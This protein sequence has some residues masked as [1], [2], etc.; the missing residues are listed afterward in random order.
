MLSKGKIRALA[1][2]SA[3]TSFSLD[4]AEVALHG[5][6]VDENDA[7]VQAA[8]VSVRPAAVPAAAA[9]SWQAQTDPDGAFIVTLPAA[10]DY[11]I[12]AE[13]EGYYALKDHA[14]HIEGA[15]ELTL[16]INSVREVFQSENVNAETSPLDVGQ[17]Q[18]QERLTGTEVNDVPY[19][20]SHSLRNSFALMPGVV[21]DATGALHANGSQENQLNYVLN[22]FNITNPISGNFQTLL[23]VEGIRDVNLAS[24][25]YSP[26][27]GKGSAGVLAIQTENGTDAFHYTA[28]DFIPGISIQNGL[29]L[30]NW[31]P[32]FGVSGPLFA[33]APGF[34]TPSIQN[35]TRAS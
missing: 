25:R 12:S 17:S 13:R 8:R 22:G 35:I 23:A 24:G 2:I 34:P 29:R 15:E 14:V 7:P 19:A 28:T 27:F 10:G 4:A 9:T 32:R 18:N 26:E 3:L 16:A 30:A 11:L 1:L 21:E 33:G 31:Y 5:R 6:V 20:N